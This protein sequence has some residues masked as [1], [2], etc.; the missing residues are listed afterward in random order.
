[1]VCGY[2]DHVVGCESPCLILFTALMGSVNLV[3]SMAGTSASGL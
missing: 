3:L 1:M 2:L